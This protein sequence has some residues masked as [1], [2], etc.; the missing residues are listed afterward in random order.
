MSADSYADLLERLFATYEGRHS[1]AAIEHI[2]TQ[3]RTE[4]AGQTPPGALFELLERLARQR[5]DDL[6]PSHPSRGPIR[7]RCCGGVAG[8]EAGKL[9][10]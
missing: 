8:A 10:G 5:L 7:H 4:L 9:S 3:C 2:T 1:L 6:P